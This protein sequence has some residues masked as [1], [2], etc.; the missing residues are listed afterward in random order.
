MPFLSLCIRNYTLRLVTAHSVAVCVAVKTSQIQLK[1]DIATVLWLF[2]RLCVR[3]VS[4]DEC[5]EINGT[6]VLA[7]NYMI[8]SINTCRNHNLSWCCWWCHF[9][10]TTKIIILLMLLTDWTSQIFLLRET[11]LY[12][13]EKIYIVSHGSNP[14]FGRIWTSHDVIGCWETWTCSRECTAYMDLF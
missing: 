5:F 9:Y 12:L 11:T 13:T 8:L 10:C 3:L 1:V 4:W 7:S 6:L 14:C 2:Y